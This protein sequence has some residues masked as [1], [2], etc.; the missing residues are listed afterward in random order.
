MYTITVSL[1]AP[2]GELM[3]PTRG[4]PAFAFPADRLGKSTAPRLLETVRTIA[5]EI[6]GTVR[7]TIEE[8]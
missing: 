6:G 2:E 5:R 4:G 1:L 7:G 3:A 8:A